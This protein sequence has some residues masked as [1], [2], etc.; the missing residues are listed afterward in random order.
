MPERRRGRPPHP[1]FLTPAERRVLDELRTGGT[2]AEIAVRIGIGPETVKTHV[3]NLLA[4][5]EFNDRHELAAWRE[6]DAP[7]RRRW[8]LRRRLG[9]RSPA[10]PLLCVPC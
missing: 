2:N 6:E 1:D 10:E 5:L 3:S 7:R 4:K 8:F 9:A